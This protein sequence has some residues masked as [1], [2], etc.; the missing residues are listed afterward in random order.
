MVPLYKAI[1]QFARQ[2]LA[3]PACRRLEQRAGV[4]RVLRVGARDERGEVSPAQRRGR[5]SVI[6]DFP[7]V[8]ASASA[9]GCARQSDRSRR[10]SAAG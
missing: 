5:I 8:R 4:D 6:A 7:W 3:K 2:F 10:R 1:W 9:G